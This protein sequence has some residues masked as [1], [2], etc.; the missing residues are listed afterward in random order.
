MP[1]R[2]P[3][4]VQRPGISPGTMAA[5]AQPKRSVTLGARP[6]SRLALLEQ[7]LLTG[8]LP[9]GVLAAPA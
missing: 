4:G 5:Y 1:N 7:P 2:K 8:V 6:A 3:E 9:L